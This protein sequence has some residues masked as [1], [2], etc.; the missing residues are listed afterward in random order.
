MKTGPSRDGETEI[1]EGLNPG[2]EVVVKGGFLL[3]SQ[4][5]RSA[6]EEK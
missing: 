3:K 1:L 2:D 6:I 4:L 5:L